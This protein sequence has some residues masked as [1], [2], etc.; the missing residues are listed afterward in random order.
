MRQNTL[1]C[2]L[3]PEKYPYE[4]DYSTEKRH[5]RKLRYFRDLD[6][7]KAWCSQH[8]GKVTLHAGSWQAFEFLGQ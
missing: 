1:E 7:L 6:E 5:S 4:V 2:W 3:Q 8:K